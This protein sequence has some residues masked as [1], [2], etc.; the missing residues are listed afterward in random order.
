MILTRDRYFYKT[1]INIAFP[2][3]LQNLITFSVSIADTI[4]LGNLGEVSLSASSIGNHLGFFFMVLMFGVGGGASVMTSQYYGKGDIQSIHKVMSIMYRLSLALSLIFVLIAI[5][6][7]ENFM[8]IYTNDLDVINSGVVYLKYIGISYIFFSLSNCTITILRSVRTV[9]ISLVMYSISLLFN[10]SFNY[11]LIFGK[12]GFPKL[13]IQGAAIATVLSR[14]VELVVIIIYINYFEKKINLKLRNIRK[15]DKLI[16][17]KFVKIGTPVILNELFW[18][19]GAT[20]ISI[21]VGRMGR[22]VVAANSI[23]NVTFQLAS[24]FIFGLASSSSVITGNTIGEGKYDKAREYANTLCVLSLLM[25][26][27]AGLTIY[28]TRPI[29]VNFYNVSDITKSIAKEIMVAT[30]IIAVF[31]SLSSSLLMGVLRGGGDNKFVFIMEI[32]F[33]WFVSI[34]LGFLGAFVWNLP[35][36]SV[37]LLIKVDEVFKGIAGVIRVSMGKCIK[38]LTR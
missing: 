28:F 37:F 23:N 7:P 18:A 35:I 8:K 29:V 32:L 19:I 25:G 38:D 9:K 13:G 11:L 26:I 2:I 21:I 15:I 5:V 27:C 33:L 20:I 12:F 16:L 31:K 17:N 6:F 22:E 30:A 36:F 4:M 3:A 1:A 34:P 24:L 14:I 10:I